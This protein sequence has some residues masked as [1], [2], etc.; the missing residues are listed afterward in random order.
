MIFSKKNR[1]K[2]E[3]EKREGVKVRLNLVLDLPAGAE[4]RGG[5]L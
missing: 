1:L 4:M 5:A 2:A 3:K